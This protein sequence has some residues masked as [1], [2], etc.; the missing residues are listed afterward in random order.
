MTDDFGNFIVMLTDCEP[1]NNINY[2]TEYQEKH[3]V[4]YVEEEMMHRVKFPCPSSVFL[5]AVMND[6]KSPS[7]LPEWAVLVSP[8]LW[9]LHQTC[10]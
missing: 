8:V 3:R 6:A 5:M 2:D 10:R 7:C 4:L 1:L 9:W